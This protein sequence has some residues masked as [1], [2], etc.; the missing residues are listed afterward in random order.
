MV[1]A[2]ELI[3][4][5][6]ENLCDLISLEKNDTIKKIKDLAAAAVLVVATA[7]FIIG[8]IIILPKLLELD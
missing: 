2:L 6:L 1:F 5:A 4:S 3:N 8:L 7:S